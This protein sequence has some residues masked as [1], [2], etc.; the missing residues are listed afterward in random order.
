[1]SLKTGFIAFPGKPT[2][3]G[4]EA[5]VAC[6]HLT[7]AHGNKGFSTWQENDIAGRFLIDPIL[8][9]IRSTDVLVADITKL[10]FN[11]AFEVGY[12]IGSRRR[13]LIVRRNDIVGDSALHAE[14]GIFDTLGYEGYTNGRQLAELIAKR[15]SDLTPLPLKVRQQGRPRLFLLEPPQKDSY[16]IALLGSLKKSKVGFEK[17]DPIEFG[18]LGAKYAI[19]SVSRE[20]ALIARTLPSLREKSLIHNIRVAFCAGISHSLGRDFLLFQDS[21][22]PIPLDYREL[23]TWA[24]D[25]K[26]I[27]PKVAELL[28]RL[29]A[30]QEIV[31]GAGGPT[32]LLSKIQIGASIAENEGRELPQY[33]LETE[34]FRDAKRGDVQIVVGRKGA[35]KT[36]FFI[37]LRN[38]LKRDPNN[39]VL[40]L[41]PEGFQIL[42]FKERCLTL[43]SEGSR[44]HLLT[45][46]WEYVVLLEIAF[47]IV[48][49]DRVSHVHNHL[50][51][52][53][54]RQL[55]EFL[56]SNA[57][58]TGISDEGDFSERLDRV[59]RHVEKKLLA[60][61]D[62]KS[63]DN[64]LTNP[65][66][67]EVLYSVDLR[68]L[69]KLVGAYI[70][71][72]NGLW[73]LVDNLDKGWPPTGVTADDTRI[74]RCLQAALTK[75]ERPYR[76]SEKVCRGVVFI[77]SDVYH[78]L[79]AATPDKGKIRKVSLDLSNKQILREI[80]R[81]RIA[82]SVGRPNATLEE[83]W[84]QIAVPH[85]SSTSEDTSDF[86]LDRA[87]MRPRNL[88][89]LVRCCMSNA[90]TLDHEKI[91]AEDLK[92]GLS[93]YSVELATN[94]GFEIQ[95]G[96][97]R[98]LLYWDL[99]NGFKRA[100]LSRF[101][102]K[103]KFQTSQRLSKS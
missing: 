91:T 73:V 79:V 97:T 52:E 85:I 14:L 98:S 41:Q 26:D 15:L 55:D 92:E 34:A 32:S 9:R 68:E 35:G 27:S 19:D 99:E 72:K 31:T 84:H 80:L 76:H 102:R 82:F 88:L 18:R 13:V 43:L 86:L 62:L 22:E 46:L 30:E 12:A 81:R 25:P 48:R 103:T 53:P 75:I 39:I 20:D 38:Y 16:D 63:A 45:A 54:Y 67:T 11:V 8:E 40:D 77:R 7:S 6:D 83:I 28:L 66:V 4:V 78:H 17:Y 57:A 74:I 47:R 51:N 61:K 87:L 101:S 21:E 95:E 24:A 10:N 59:L 69:Q 44:E 56:S 93:S 37:Q 29:Y 42:K 36:A 60:R 58:T 1:M 71:Q 49:D 50:L 5:K 65:V 89:D 23:V 3:I 64:V 33:Y 96:S 100:N 70:E 90:I 94:I 2:E